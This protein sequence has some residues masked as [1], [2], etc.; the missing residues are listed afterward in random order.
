MVHSTY[1]DRFD[2]LDRLAQFHCA[3]LLHLGG[4]DGFRQRTIGELPV[5]DKFV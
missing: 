1:R 5:Q 2:R 4:W 3:F